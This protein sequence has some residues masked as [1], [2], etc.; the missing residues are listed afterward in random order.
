MLSKNLVTNN[1]EKFFNAMD[2]M[3]HI[4]IRPNIEKYD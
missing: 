1:D 3:V 4:S 2:R